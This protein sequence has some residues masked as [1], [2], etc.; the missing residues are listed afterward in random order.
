MLNKFLEADLRGDLD[1][2]TT[3]EI[4]FEEGNLGIPV[5]LLPR[6]YTEAWHSFKSSNDN[7]LNLSST[8]KILL[9][10]NPECST[11]WNYRRKL[12][13]KGILIASKEYQF[14]SFL[15]TKHSSK[16]RIW[17]YRSWLLQ[18]FSIPTAENTD[19]KYCN[20]TADRYRCNY[21]SWGYRRSQILSKLQSG[22]EYTAELDEN[23]AFI[24]VHVS[25]SSGWS[26]RQAI[27]LHFKMRPHVLE[28]KWTMDMIEFYPGHESIW[29]HLRFVCMYAEDPEVVQLCNDFAWKFPMPDKLMNMLKAMQAHKQLSY[30]NDGNLDVTQS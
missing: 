7:I 23:K 29:C 12:L 9:L 11:L 28:A 14:T 24:K 18:Y 15:L 4:I 19:L 20:V 16:G 8:T 17:D 27:F 25:D 30:E 6:I 22:T 2:I 21:P 13:Q 10:F 26:Y 5:S 3:D 1:F